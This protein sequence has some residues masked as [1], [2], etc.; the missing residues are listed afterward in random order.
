MTSNIEGR[1]SLALH[2]LRTSQSKSLRAATKVYD[3][4]YTT[5]NKRYY[6]IYS[7]QETRHPACKLTQTE[8]EVLL[9]RILDLDEQGFPLQQA[10]VRDIAAIILSNRSEQPPLTLGKNWITSF[11]RRH[12]S[13][14]TKYN[15]KYD[16][17]RAICKDLKQIGD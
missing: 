5:L 11:I 13:L 2:S 3:V 7:R 15:R 1:I 4:P 10:V 14:Q 8:E 9:Q 16:Y 6:G 17:Q 12:P